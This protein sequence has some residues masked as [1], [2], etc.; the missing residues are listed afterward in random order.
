MKIDTYNRPESGNDYWATA[1]SLLADY[2]FTHSF[3]AYVGVMEMEYRGDALHKHAP[4]DAYSSNGMYGMGIR[5]R[6]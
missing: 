1:Y 3:D 4:V 5:Y 2:Q 6:F